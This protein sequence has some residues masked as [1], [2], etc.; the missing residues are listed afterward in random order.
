M[1]V[2]IMRYFLMTLAMLTLLVSRCSGQSRSLPSKM[3][4]AES[5]RDLDISSDQQL[6][7]IVRGSPDGLKAARD[8][9][10]AGIAQPHLLPFIDGLG[11]SLRLRQAVALAERKDITQIWYISPSMY[12]SYLR[13]ID[14]IEHATKTLPSPSLINLSL[15]PPADALPLRGDDDEPMSVATKKAA[16][17]GLIVVMAVGNYYDGTDDGVV[18]PWCH[19]EWVI[20]VGAASADAKTM[21]NG[22]ARGLASDP[23]TWP[24]VVANGIDVVGPWPTTMEKPENRRKYDE[25]NPI[26]QSAVP[27]EKWNLYTLDSGTS[28]AV[29]QVTKA[30]A[31][32]IAFIREILRSK[33]GVKPGGKLFA[34]DVPADRFNATSRRGPRLTGDVQKE[35]GDPSQF[36]ITY[37]LVEPWKLV[38]QLLMDS[39]VP[40][41]TFPPS[42]VGAGFVDPAYV[43]KQFPTAEKNEIEIEPIKVL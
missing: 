39:A 38:K 25:A 21:W 6:G 20:C 4:P 29:P 7:F 9:V 36:E 31:Q 28:E 13:I 22:S 15:G 40:M 8:S 35:E 34:I 2:H 30:A 37:R 3:G 32:I 42:V 10:P 1:T 17:A 27:K 11:I 24:D 26:F 33:P 14:G 5:V 18:N 43:E 12:P 23:R 16:D 41:P 19:P